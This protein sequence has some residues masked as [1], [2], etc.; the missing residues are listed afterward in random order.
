MGIRGDHCIANA[1]KC[2]APSLFRL[3]QLLLGS[4]LF[5]DVPTD[6]GSS[7]HVAVVIKEW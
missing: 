2:D 3:K 5:R 1:L 4:F 7:D 6:C